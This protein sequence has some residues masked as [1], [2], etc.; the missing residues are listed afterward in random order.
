M[1]TKLVGM[2][3]HQVPIVQTLRTIVVPSSI[4][5]GS[6]DAL[7]LK[8]MPIIVART[9]ATVTLTTVVVVHARLSLMKIRIVDVLVLVVRTRSVVLML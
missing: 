5:Q 2:I 1:T 3:V 8:T 7:T 9:A 6:M 4:Q